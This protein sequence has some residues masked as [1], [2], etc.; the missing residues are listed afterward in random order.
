[1]DVVY[2]SYRHLGKYRK[3]IKIAYNCS[4]Y[5]EAFNVSVTTFA[6]SF[7]IAGGFALVC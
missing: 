5:K 6:A 2:I 7:S 1:M 3:N 4:T